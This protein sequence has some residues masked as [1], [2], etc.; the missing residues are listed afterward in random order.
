MS[1]FNNQNN[2]A[3][4]Q[5]Y[6]PLTNDYNNPS[7]NM[8]QEPQI[9]QTN[10]TPK[11]N[12]LNKN[13]G[14]YTI[15]KTPYGFCQI[16]PLITLIIMIVGS[17]IFI[18]FVLKMF[19]SYFIYI[20]ILFPICCFIMGFCITSVYYII[21]DSSQKRI[22]LKRDKIFKTSEIIKINDIQKVNFE[23][24]EDNESG[25]FFKINFILVNG[26]TV[27]AVNTPDQ[28]GEYLKAFQSLKNRLPQEIY[29]EEV[30]NYGNNCLF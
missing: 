8:T 15:Y 5:N 11:E 4:A 30:C 17:I 1:D 14:E 7:S 26:R 13:P 19:D 12:G 3:S 28:G 22:I 6:S 21:Y 23:K 27:T 9:I 29:F 16:C 18:F 25:H 2:I 20:Q 10:I 24:Y